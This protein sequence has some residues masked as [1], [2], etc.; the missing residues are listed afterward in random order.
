MTACLPRAGDDYR[1]PEMV[2]LVDTGIAAR[3]AIANT[4]PTTLALHPKVT[5]VCPS[6]TRLPG[7]D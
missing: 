6:R 7:H 1:T 2:A 5:N 4:V 3:L